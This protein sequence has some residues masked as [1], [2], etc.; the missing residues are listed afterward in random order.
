M[1]PTR[2]SYLMIDVPT[3]GPMNAAEEQSSTC[4]P[5]DSSHTPNS[6]VF[7]SQSENPH[8]LNNTYM[9]TADEH[10]TCCYSIP[11]QNPFDPL[12]N[13]EQE[14]AATAEMNQTEGTDSHTPVD[15]T[16]RRHRQENAEK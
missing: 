12:L 2:D 3:A 9:I 8:T 10:E 15:T 7:S 14:K 16:Q 11:T 1:I 5:T 6:K 13:T 4:S